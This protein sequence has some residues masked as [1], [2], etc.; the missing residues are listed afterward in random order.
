MSASA[1][2]NF[3]ADDQKWAAVCSNNKDADGHFWYAVTSTGIVCN[4]SCPSRVPHRKN[5]LFF[6][7]LTEAL[8]EGFRSCRRCKP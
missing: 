7:V 2:M 8:R 1:A 5:V 4:P 6:D 3:G